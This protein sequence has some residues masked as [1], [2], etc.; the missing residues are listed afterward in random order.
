MEAGKQNSA[1]DAKKCRHRASTSKSAKRQE[2]PNTSLN[3]LDIQQEEMTAVS[4]I[5]DAGQHRY[6]YGQDDKILKM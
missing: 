5:Y 4:L 2:G 1:L 3:S 6:Y